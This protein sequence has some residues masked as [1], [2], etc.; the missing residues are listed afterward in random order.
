MDIKELGFVL[1]V[2]LYTV[3][4]IIDLADDDLSI[5]KRIAILDHGIVE[6]DLRALSVSKLGDFVKAVSDAMGAQANP[7]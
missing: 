3:G 5:A 2:S 1:D 7:T 4:D 6:G